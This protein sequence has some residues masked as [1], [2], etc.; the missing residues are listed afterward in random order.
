MIKKVLMVFLPL[1]AVGCVIVWFGDDLLAKILTGGEYPEVAPILRYFIP[2]LF[3]SFPAIL[4]GWPVLGAIGKTKETT[5]T[6]I[7]CAVVQVLGLVVLLLTDHFTLFNLAMLRAA[8][9]LL[10]F[11]LR[12][13][14]CVRHRKEF[15]Q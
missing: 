14:V 8:T 2:L 5:I 3:I 1:I 7:I 15:F 9:D 10:M 11:I 13:G 6:T 4:F 12:A